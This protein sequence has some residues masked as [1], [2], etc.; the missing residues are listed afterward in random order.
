MWKNVIYFLICLRVLIFFN[1]F[2]YFL[3]RFFLLGSSFCVFEQ[4]LVMELK[5]FHKYLVS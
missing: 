4:A 1:V 5:V 2:F 3:N